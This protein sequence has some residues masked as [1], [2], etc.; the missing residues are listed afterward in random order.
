MAHKHTKQEDERREEE[1]A[2]E[3]GSSRV[4]NIYLKSQG[5]GAPYIVVGCLEPKLWFSG[6]NPNFQFK[7]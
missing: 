6:G 1:E 5:V 4:W 2:L 3:F 7:A